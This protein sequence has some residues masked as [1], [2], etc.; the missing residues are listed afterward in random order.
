MS[1]ERIF[2]IPKRKAVIAIV[3]AF[4]VLFIGV[5]ASFQYA[6]YVNRQSNQKWCGII[7]LFDD[8][9]AESPPP[10]ETGKKLA[11]EFN[12]LRNAPDYRCK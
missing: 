8:T 3:T 2:V 4:V 7:V 5:I 6:N 11:T 1:D 9:Y 10:S 12:N